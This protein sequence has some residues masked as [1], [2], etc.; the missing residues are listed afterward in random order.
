MENKEVI[1]W[2]NTTSKLSQLI[3]WTNNPRFSTK[4]QA[5]RLLESWKELGQFQTVAIGPAGE[6]Y[7]G[8]QRLSA[9]LTVFG[10]DYEIDVRKSS[11]S[12]NDDERKK[13]I[14]VT[15]VGTVGSWDW[16]K[17]SGWDAKELQ[18]WGMDSES[19]SN[20]NHDA[21]NL[22]E[23]M[24]A[25]FEYKPNFDPQFGNSSVDEFDIA[26][27]K[28]ELESRFDGGKDSLE[29]FC[30]HCAKEFFLAVEQV[31]HEIRLNKAT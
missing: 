31:L 18:G 4:S 27:K 22:R 15:H 7:D 28:Q 2:L 25:D 8:H 20:W 16:D 3:P 6:V 23:M 29:V 26:K 12:L 17:L 10:G 21:N 14:I 11:R 13:L 30:P 19:L 5:K 24:S 1:T 9:L